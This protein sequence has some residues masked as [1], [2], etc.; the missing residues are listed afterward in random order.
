[1][2]KKDERR[3]S[4]IPLGEFV[5]LKLIA[6]KPLAN[7]GRNIMNN[8]NNFF[9]SVSL[10]TKLLAKKEAKDNMAYSITTKVYKTDNSILIIYK[11]KPK[12]N[13]LF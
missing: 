13:Y 2:L 7:C 10:A 8:I 4:S 1:M 9:T 6:F 3:K 11:S 12:K 5:A